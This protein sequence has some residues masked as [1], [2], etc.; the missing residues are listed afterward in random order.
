MF[1]LARSQS[2]TDG[3]VQDQFWEYVQ[4]EA[5]KRGIR[6]ILENRQKFILAHSSSG[7]KYLILYISL[8]LFLLFVST[9]LSYL[10]YV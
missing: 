9:Y 7:H 8:S 5:T 4:R 1:T 2:S 3:T 10:L 6:V